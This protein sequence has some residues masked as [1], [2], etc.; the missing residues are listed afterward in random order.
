[1]WTYITYVY[2][3]NTAMQGGLKDFQCWQK[4]GGLFEFLGGERVRVKRGEW[5]FSVGV[6][7]G[8]DLLKV[9][10]NC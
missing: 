7:G 9:I 4:G 3:G 8:E 2:L 5:I 6:R 10:F 1:M